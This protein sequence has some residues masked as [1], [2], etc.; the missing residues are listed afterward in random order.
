MASRS[1]SR[2]TK[3]CS[4]SFFKPTFASSPSN[5]PVP[6]QQPTFGSRNSSNSWC[7]FRNLT[8]FRFY[9][10][11]TSHSSSVR[12]VISEG[13]PKFETFEIDPPKK[14][15]WQ[16]KKRLK[17]KR[18]KEKRKRKSANKNDPRRLT[19]KGSKRKTKF[20]NAEE[21]IKY[22]LEKVTFIFFLYIF[23]VYIKL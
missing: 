4:A 6:S 9:G 15:K 20:A 3:R 19:I 13:K 11:P 8:S 10:S 1:I 7:A 21:K 23:C 14:Y 18:K 16:T 22:K 2:F 12:C 17:L 5:R